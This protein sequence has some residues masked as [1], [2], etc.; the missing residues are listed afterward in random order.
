MATG[1]LVPGNKMPWDVTELSLMNSLPN[2]TR[3]TSQVRAMTEDCGRQ[4]H[5]H[6]TGAAAAC[7]WTR[8]LNHT[9]N[10]NVGAEEA[11]NS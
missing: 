1:V 10:A 11:R 3:E 2:D 9:R 5:C 7:P 6:R 4:Q 8:S